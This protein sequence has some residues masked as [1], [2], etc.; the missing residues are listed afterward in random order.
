MFILVLGYIKR[1]L[2]IKNMFEKLFSIIS[3][4][5]NIKTIAFLADGRI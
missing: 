4:N 3:Q 2:W 5:A 1:Q